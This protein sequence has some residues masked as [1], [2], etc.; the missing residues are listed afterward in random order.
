MKIGLF[1]CFLLSFTFVSGQSPA[2]ESFNFGFYLF[3]L[4]HVF[5]PSELTAFRPSVASLT[6]EEWAVAFL[7]KNSSNSNT[8]NLVILF[9]QIYGNTSTNLSTFSLPT[10]SLFC[11]QKSCDIMKFLVS[12]LFSFKTAAPILASHSIY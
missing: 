4:G 1:L 6:A 8:T 11:P 7:A 2:S 5:S 9:N 10:M 12:S 3:N